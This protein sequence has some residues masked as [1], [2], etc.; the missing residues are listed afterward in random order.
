MTDEH[1]PPE[2]DEAELRQFEHKLLDELA[3]LASHGSVPAINSATK[4]LADLRARRLVDEL[5]RAIADDDR[6]AIAYQLGYLGI[7]G[8]DVE[9]MLPGG[10]DAGELARYDRGQ[11]VRRLEIR[12]IQ[13]QAAATNGKIEDWMKK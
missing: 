10:P 11:L 9:A 13:M 7:K 8:A 2:I 4:M 12:A 3:K 1:Q 6:P 5:N